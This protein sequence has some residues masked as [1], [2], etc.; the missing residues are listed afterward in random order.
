[1]WRIWTYHVKGELRYL[2]LCG[3]PHCDGCQEASLAIDAVIDAHD[4]DEAA[5]ILLE[6]TSFTADIDAD[7]D[8]LLEQLH[9][10]R[11]SETEAVYQK[12][13]RNGHPTLFDLAA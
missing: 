8:D 6:E 3:C 4:K 7:I 10:N 13:L 2:T 11:L 1:M 9:F 5:R 12:N